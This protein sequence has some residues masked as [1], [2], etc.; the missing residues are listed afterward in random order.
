[1]QKPSGGEHE[2]REPVILKESRRRQAGYLKTKNAPRIEH[3][4]AV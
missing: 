3:I 1:L 4:E 2:R